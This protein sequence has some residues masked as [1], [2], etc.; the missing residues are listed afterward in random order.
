MT[1]RPRPERASEREAFPDAAYRGA[2][3][4]LV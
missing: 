2:E 1:E 3:E 4:P